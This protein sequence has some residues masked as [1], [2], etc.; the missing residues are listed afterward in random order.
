MIDMAD[1]D[2]KLII[3]TSKIQFDLKTGIIYTYCNDCGSL[4]LKTP[5]EVMPYIDGPISC[6]GK[7]RM[8]SNLNSN[9]YSITGEIT[10]DQ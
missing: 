2:E 5:R 8:P 3:G 1:I 6:C 7:L 9:S 4:L 10:N